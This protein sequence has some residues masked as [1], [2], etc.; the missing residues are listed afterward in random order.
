MA[1]QTPNHREVIA[2]VS[3]LTGKPEYLTSTNGALDVDVTVNTGATT[4]ANVYTGQQTAGGSATQFASSLALSNGIIIKA[5]ATNTGTVYIGASSV[6]SSTG[7]PL[8]AGDAVSI[9]VSDLSL[10]YVT[11]NGTDRISWIC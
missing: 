11:G 2:A 1:S 4:N 5:L 7:V 10:M 9:A 8:T 3:T 6:S